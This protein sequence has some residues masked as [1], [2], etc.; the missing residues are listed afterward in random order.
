M[1]YEEMSDFEINVEVAKASGLDVQYQSMR[2]DGRV[3]VVVKIDCG[4]E[5]YYRVPDYCNSW[6]DAGPVILENKIGI[7]TTSSSCEW[8]ARTCS[9]NMSSMM[10]RCGKHKN[11]LRAAMIVFLMMKDAEK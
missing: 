2:N 11:P 9:T 5:R 3:L 8:V 1:N 10:F 6:D 7:E 4:V